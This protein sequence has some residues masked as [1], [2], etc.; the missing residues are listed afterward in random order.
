MV[1]KKNTLLNIYTLQRAIKEL[2]KDHL[3]ESAVIAI[4]C[5]GHGK[6]IYNISPVL[7]NN[8]QSIL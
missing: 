6:Y 2:R 4:D 1:V 3:K 8:S 5:R 7:H